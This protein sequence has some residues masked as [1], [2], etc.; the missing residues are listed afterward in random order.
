MGQVIDQSYPY[1]GISM[2]LVGL[3]YSL[4]A[5]NK[6]ISDFDRRGALTEIVLFGIQVLGLKLARNNPAYLLVPI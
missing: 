5:S 4:C 6:K 2:H 1:D 3:Q